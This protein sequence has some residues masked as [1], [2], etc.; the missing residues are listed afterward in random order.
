MAQLMKDRLRIAAYMS[1]NQ[2]MQAYVLPVCH[3]RP[4]R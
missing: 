4:R 3:V 2:G 1:R